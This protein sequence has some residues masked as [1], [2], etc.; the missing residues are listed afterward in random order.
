MN[1]KMPKITAAQVMS[2]ITF[3]VT[4]A[5]AAGW[6]NAGQEQKIVQIAGVVLPGVWMIV[7]AM[8]RRG[9]ARIHVATIE[10]EAARVQAILQHHATVS[11]NAV[12]LDPEKSTSEAVAI[13]NASAPA[14][15][16]P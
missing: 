4:Q 6:M 10:A 2:L 5:V 11:A 9:R 15:S 13:V 14:P 7:D 1:P 16:G 3:A 8:L 12:G